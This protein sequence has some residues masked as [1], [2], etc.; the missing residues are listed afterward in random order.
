MSPQAGGGGL[1][2]TG[3]M[4]D[5]VRVERISDDIGLGICA[6]QPLAQA[7]V[8]WS[9]PPAA[10]V[11]ALVNRGVAACAHCLRCLSDSHS[12]VMP[13][14]L[15][16]L[17][18]KCWPFNPAEVR[19]CSGCSAI[20]CSGACRDQAWLQYHQLECSQHETFL[21][22]DAWCEDCLSPFLGDCLRLT[23]RLVCCMAAQH[24]RAGTPLSSLL[25]HL[26][27]FQ[28]ADPYE[29]EAYVPA[30]RQHLHSLSS[31]LAC[32]GEGGRLAPDVLGLFTAPKFLGLL[33]KVRNTSMTI[34]PLS[35]HA[36]FVKNATGPS[37]GRERLEVMQRMA[38]DPDVNAFLA[39]IQQDHPQGVALFSWLPFLN[40]SCAPN[41]IAS[42]T[43]DSTMCIS[44]HRDIGPGDQVFISYIGAG[45]LED[46]VGRRRMLRHNWGFECACPRCAAG[47]GGAEPRPREAGLSGRSDVNSDAHTTLGARMATSNV[48]SADGGAAR[49][50]QTAREAQ[51]RAER[52]KVQQLRE[53]VL[54]AKAR[55]QEL[56]RQ[57][58][59]LDAGLLDPDG[60]SDPADEPVP[61]APDADPEPCSGYPPG[62]PTSSAGNA[63]RL[64]T[65]TSRLGGKQN[66]RPSPCTKTQPT[67]HLNAEP[68]GHRSA[69]PCATADR[70]HHLDPN[71]GHCA[72][73]TKPYST[74]SSK[75][76]PSP[77]PVKLTA[78]PNRTLL[79]SSAPHPY[80]SLGHTAYGYANSRSPNSS[81]PGPYVS[82]ASLATNFTPSAALT[83]HSAVPSNPSNAVPWPGARLIPVAWQAHSARPSW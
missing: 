23:L 53:E 43:L 70:C 50:L 73:N 25:A 40:H 2:L 82:R 38:V 79:P 9:E 64:H 10:C 72:P 41:A 69:H 42:V 39:A 21:S 8:L 48:G 11:Q 24:L 17:V 29:A 75:P 61:C 13:A 4:P 18:P 55:T 52:A 65:Q 12:V 16:A 57:L 31:G 1:F 37:A 20:Y 63:P 7:D 81:T 45:N 60:H 67:R 15:Q 59:A 32:S 58:Q 3:P 51:L 30:L 19:K 5:M 56:E 83:G 22:I 46:V 68:A 34:T 54:Q 74:L 77:S 49:G 44:V 78:N 14:Y 36:A 35:A 71:F 27:Q 80:F 6:T 76:S 62:S 26:E 28:G 33:Q 66:P 47:A